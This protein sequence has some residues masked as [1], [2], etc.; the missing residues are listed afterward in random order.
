MSGNMVKLGSK[1]RAKE[2]GMGRK[3]DMNVCKREKSIPFCFSQSPGIKFYGC[4]LPLVGPSPRV[5]AW[6]SLGSKHFPL[7]L[8]IRDQF[9]NDS[10]QINASQTTSDEP[11]FF[12][13]LYIR[14]RNQD[15]HFNSGSQSIP[16]Q[17]CAFFFFS[18][19]H[20]LPCSQVRQEILSLD[21][22]SFFLS[23]STP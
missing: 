7:L 6:E 20:P 1:K 4:F 21:T 5:T 10:C 17:S 8:S 3:G 11:F 16:S 23:H 9:I 18:L 2:G 22:F 15:I 13:L 19:L 14:F 12:L